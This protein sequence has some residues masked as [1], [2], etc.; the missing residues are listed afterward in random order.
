MYNN[1][2]YAAYSEMMLNDKLFK[3]VNTSKIWIYRVTIATVTVTVLQRDV[4]Q[5]TT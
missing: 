5:I 3:I 1:N 2:L 4:K